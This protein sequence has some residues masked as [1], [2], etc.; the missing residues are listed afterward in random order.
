VL[1]DI[2]YNIV[3]DILLKT[4][5]EEKMA[6]ASSAAIVVEQLAAQ[7]DPTTTDDSSAT[8]QAPSQPDRDIR[9]HI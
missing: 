9:G 1:D 5:R 8:G 4:H 7:A 3:H 2:V 6:R